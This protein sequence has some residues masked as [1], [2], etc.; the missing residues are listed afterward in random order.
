M[1]GVRSFAGAFGVALLV[2]LA[3]ASAAGCSW[4][5]GVSDDPVVVDGPAAEGG[6]EAAPDAAAD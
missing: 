2:A 6:D 1:R 3:A 5:L 4:I